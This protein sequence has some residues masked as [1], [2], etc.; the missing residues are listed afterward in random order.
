MFM[1]ERPRSTAMY[2][3]RVRVDD[4]ANP[5]VI[6]PEEIR[7]SPLAERQRQR[8]QSLAPILGIPVDP[9]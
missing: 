4:I 3:A 8:Q 9:I 2:V 7:R 5:D 1:R 6:V